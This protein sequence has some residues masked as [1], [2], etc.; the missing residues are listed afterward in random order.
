VKWILPIAVAL[1]LA[2]LALNSFGW[3]EVARSQ[4]P[5][6]RKLIRIEEFPRGPDSTIRAEIQEGFAFQRVVLPDDAFVGLIFIA[7]APDSS[8]VGI[9]VGNPIGS[10]LRISFDLRAWRSVSFETVRPLVEAEI[11][12][13][14]P[15]HP[16]E[17]KRFGGD[18]V[19]WAERKR[20][21]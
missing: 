10:G 20:G 9:L 15:P 6:G 5:D 17:L 14:F 8:L 7:W 2:Y 11:L 12:R 16:E 21:L 19:L 3:R 4:S 13:Q 1:N 18:L